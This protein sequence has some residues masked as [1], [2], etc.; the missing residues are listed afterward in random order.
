MTIVRH[1]STHS[2]PRPT[3][4]HEQLAQAEE[5]LRT[6]IDAE[7]E[8]VKLVAAD[9]ELLKMNA[10]GLAILEAESAEQ[11][12]GACVF[13][14]I[15]P[16]H[17]DAFRQMHERVIAGGRETLRFEVIGLRG[18]RR[19]I[20]TRAVPLRLGASPVP[21][22]LAISR[23]VTKQ[24]QTT[25]FLYSQNGLLEQIATKAPL[26][27]ILRGIVT[28]IEEQA[29]EVLCSILL[30]EPDGV[31]LRMA[32]A[33]RLPP[34]YNAAIDRIA[35]G[36][37]AG[38]CGAAAYRCQPVFVA[39]VASDP[40]WIDCKDLALAHGF[41]A[42]WS[43]PIMSRSPGGQPAAVLGT[44]ACYLRRPGLPDP[45][46]VELL[47]RAENL[48]RIALES[49]RADKELREREAFLRMSQ[50]NGR[51]GSWEWN[52]TTNRVKWSEEMAQIHG[53]RL[54]EFDGTLEMAASF[55]HPDDASLFRRHVEELGEGSD[56]AQ[57]EYR[58]RRADGAIR[59]LWPAAEVIRDA[60]GRPLKLMGVSMDITERIQSQEALRESEQRFRQLAET[61]IEGLMI[62]EQ[63]VIRYANRRFAQS[64]GFASA[65]ELIGRFGVDSLPFTPESREIIRRHLRFPLET[66]IEVE[67]VT[68]DGAIRTFETQAQDINYHGRQARVV[69][70]RDVTERKSRE[71]SLLL[72]RALVDRLNDAIEVIDAPTG[73]FLDV[74]ERACLDLGYSRDELLSLSIPDV[75]PL[76]SMASYQQNVEQLRDTGSF[77]MKTLNRRKDGTCFPVEVNARLVQLDREYLLSV[78]RDISERVQ[79]E[80]ALRDSEERFRSAFAWSTIGMSLVSLEGRWLKVN[81]SLC[82]ML[83]YSA[84]ELLE[85][86]FQSVTH[87]DDLE[88]G[89]EFSRRLIAGVASCCHF[90]KRYIH[91]QG[92]VIRVLLSVS[93][94]RD[95][96]GV[97]LYFVGQTQDITER[98]RLE[99]QVR[100]AQKMEA[101]GRLAGG[102]AHDF[103]NVLTV[104]N[105]HSQLLLERTAPCDRDYASL[106]AIHEAGQRAASLVR[107]LLA[108]S[109]SQALHPAP[110]DLNELVAQFE[111]LIGRLLGDQVELRVRCAPDLA[112]VRADRSQMEQVLMNLVVNARD[113]M[114]YGGVLTIETGNVE[115]SERRVGIGEELKPG[116]HVRLSVADTGHGMT[117]EVQAKIFEPFFTTKEI[118]KGTGLGLP[119]VHGIVQ[120]SGGQVEVESA[121]GAG[122]RIVILL[123][124]ESA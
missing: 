107:Q 115:L 44:F 22:H 25:D 105:G 122:A 37:F 67:T 120:Q 33:P 16:E 91:K 31:H 58:I 110:L 41:R 62:H 7:P 101:V 86:D 75:D 81:Q 70:T 52:Y 92:S 109:R 72:F 8:C 74:N 104:V 36:P 103:N 60:A 66:M 57:W 28:A 85:L 117:A 6:L 99:E 108:F 113:A 5:F 32:S 95:G 73:R 64:F 116:R 53:I 118:G 45:E 112:L 96:A 13:D 123:P 97:P 71:Q 29:P 10:A 34:E 78:V 90:E 9:G 65:E 30:M 35:I 84:E 87:R 102:I 83:G 69:A 121:A 4:L 89:P 59:H 1:D 55:F 49:E 124:A 94:V 82:D 27:D 40:L 114:P 100:H 20:E 88:I 48:I 93:L 54:D 39:D 51:V 50:R 42:C 19:W 43:T 12:L 17:R 21:L 76:V 3:C 98:R 26:S 23:D 15:A 14:L 68:P 106:N 80:E 18:A 111:N 24:K 77:T 119:A 79:F 47:K 61:A 2:V 63:G 11:L 46:F 56:Y 38:S